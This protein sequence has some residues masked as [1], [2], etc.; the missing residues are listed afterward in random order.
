M[1]VAAVVRRGEGGGGGVDYL[2]QMTNVSNLGPLR[3][4]YLVVGI[5]RQN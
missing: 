5:S 1:V 4:H 2:A 3:F